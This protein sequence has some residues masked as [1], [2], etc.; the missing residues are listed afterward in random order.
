MFLREHNQIANI[1]AAIN[2]HWTDEELYQTA[3]K[4]IVAMTQH[5]TYTEYLPSVLDP[6][7]RQVYGLMGPSLGYTSYDV[8]I[9]A[10]ISNSFAVAAFR[11]AHS[12]IP[13]FIK[14]VNT[15]HKTFHH[16]HNGHFQS[17]NFGK[18]YIDIFHHQYGKI[19]CWMSSFGW[20]L[21][22]RNESQHNSFL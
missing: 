7:T 13:N 18:L 20:D 4:I 17:T 1:L 10:T 15:Y 16:K 21:R 9:D 12:T 8:T 14:L 11:F 6:V 5:I 19:V 22:R 2:P 3:R